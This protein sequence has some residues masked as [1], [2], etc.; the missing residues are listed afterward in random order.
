MKHEKIRHRILIG[1]MCL[2][3]LLFACNADRDCRQDTDIHVNVVFTGDSL[4]LTTDSIKLSID[5]TACDTIRF[6]VIRDMTIRGMGRDSLL[7]DGLAM[8]KAKLP[9][10]PDT[11]FSDFVIDFN[12]LTDTMRIYHQNDMQFISLA[13]GCFVFHTLDS[14]RFTKAFMDSVII[15]NTAVTTA[16]D[17]HLRIYFHK[18]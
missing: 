10:K 12:G 8:N 18:R 17:D 11:T 13:C 7:A 2:T 16:T 9:L 4:R 6:N 3:G 15:L 5:S 1:L 14:I